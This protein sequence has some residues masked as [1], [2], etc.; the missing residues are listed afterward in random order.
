M[1]TTP[2]IVGIAEAIATGHF[3]S[4]D[5]LPS[6]LA[7]PLLRIKNHGVASTTASSAQG[8][9]EDNAK[10][11][12]VIYSSFLEPLSAKEVLAVARTAP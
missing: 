1:H 8:I 6:I 10:D 12:E 5:A 9:E 7:S 3:P 4:E 11:S 2:A